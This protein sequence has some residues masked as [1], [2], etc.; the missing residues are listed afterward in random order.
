VPE[1]AVEIE[2]VELELDLTYLEY[3][4]RIL[5]QKDRETRRRTIQFYKVQWNKHST[6]EATWKSEDYLRTNHLGFLTDE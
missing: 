4:I 2:E 5:D 1:Q 3:P 6:E